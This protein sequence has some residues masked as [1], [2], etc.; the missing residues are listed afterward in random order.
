VPPFRG[1]AV[2]VIDGDKPF[3][4]LEIDFEL[5]EQRKAAEFEKL[6]RVISFAQGT[7]CRQQEILEYFGQ[8]DSEACG[9]CDN[10]ARQRPEARAR[11]SAAASVVASPRLEEVVRI[12][13][14]GVARGRS[15]FGKILIAAMLC[16]SKSAKVKKFGLDRLS[17]Y[18]LLRPLRQEDVADL[19]SALIS[20]GF[21]EQVELE[22]DRPIVRLSELGQTLMAAPGAV[23]LRI[24]LSQEILQKLDSVQHVESKPASAEPAARPTS[25]PVSESGLAA[26]PAPDAVVETRAAPVTPRPI[27]ASAPLVTNG[28]GSHYWTWRLLSKGFTVDECAAIRSLERE[29]VLDHALRA[30][31]CGWQVE[32]AWFLASD[33]VEALERVIG[34]AEPSRVRPLLAKLPAGIRYEDVQLFLKCRKAGGAAPDQAS[35]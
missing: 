35:P 15:R 27:A 31:D 9:H 24:S 12:A 20:A 21:V 19:L 1:R 18:G 8:P 29:V 10:C 14:S 13:L 34:A 17:T 28:Q 26:S 11:S 5:L 16:G 22:T 23:P 30:I 7:R 25:Q 2:H 3:H 33:Q 6:R 4:E 32:V